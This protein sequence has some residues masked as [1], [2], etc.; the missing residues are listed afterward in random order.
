MFRGANILNNVLKVQYVL[1]INVL[2]FIV[3]V[4]PKKNATLN[5]SQKWKN[6]MRDFVENT[7]PYLEQY[8]QRQGLYLIVESEVRI[9]DPHKFN[10]HHSQIITHRFNHHLDVPH[11]RSLCILLWTP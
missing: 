4:I 2:T 10:H 6:T 3:F 9:R 11:L 8:H 1:M 5:G 7:M